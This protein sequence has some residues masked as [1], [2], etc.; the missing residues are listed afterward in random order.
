MTNHSIK[1]YTLKN[2]KG[3]EVDL[4]NIGA[5]IYRLLLPTSEGN[6]VNIVL[7]YTDLD[8]YISNPYYL[9]C[10]IGP[11]A[12]RINKGQYFHEGKVHHLD[13][14]HG[15]HHLHGGFQ[16]LSFQYWEV[17]HIEEKQLT[18]SCFLPKEQ[19]NYPGSLTCRVEYE[20]TEGNELIIRY[21]AEVDEAMPVSL[22]NHSYFNLSGESSRSILDHGLRIYA[23]KTL[24]VD[25]ALIPTGQQISV[26]GSIFDFNQLKTIESGIH[27]PR[28]IPFKGYDHYFVLKEKSIKKTK[29][30]AELFHAGSGRK[31]E[32]WTTL[33]G[34]QLYTGNFLNDKDLLAYSGL[35]LETQY[36]P[37]S[38]NYKHF[39]NCILMPEETYIHETIY[40]F[41]F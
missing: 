29:R 16:G 15:K 10:A 1:S 31:M 2:S 30:A 21:W 7:S 25:E 3:V 18:F 36:F 26:E 5:S 6:K 27:D 11:F 13:L 9:G 8:N 19:S 28:L 33:P 37:D 20:L 38:P 22:T 14:N 35:C 17:D 23:D 40:R 32:V 41:E 12:N 39:P 34:L 24:A 4:L